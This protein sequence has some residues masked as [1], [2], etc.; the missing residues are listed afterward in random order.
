MRVGMRMRNILILIQIVLHPDRGGTT[1][2][3]VPGVSP[4]ASRGI[5]RGSRSGDGVCGRGDGGIVGI[6]WAE[7]VSGII[8]G[9][10]TYLQPPRRRVSLQVEYEP[11]R[12]G[13]KE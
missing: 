7:P 12:T 2:S 10:L 1:P 6:G 9:P 5:P 3:G 13:C 8:L 11:P 4:Y